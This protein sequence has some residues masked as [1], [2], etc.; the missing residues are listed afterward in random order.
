MRKKIVNLG[1]AASGSGTDVDS[2]MKAWIQGCLP[3]INPKLLI[4]T[5]SGAGCLSKADGYHL[6]AVTIDRAKSVSSDD[7]NLRILRRLKDKNIELFFLLGCIHRIIPVDGIDT[8]NIHPADPGRHGGDR[9]YGLAVHLHVLE[10]INDLIYRGRKKIT[11]RFYTFP[12]VHEVTDA[13][14]D[15]GNILLQQT[16]EIPKSIVRD[17]VEGKKDE[18]LVAEELQKHVLPYEWLMLPAA[19]KMAAQR[20]LDE[21]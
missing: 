11:D 3:E 4:S 14:Y 20:I 19:V 8:Y 5:K 15:A 7:F 16:V 13:K 1:F 18:L 2:V 9:M 17:Y 6:S 21:E 12:T 10:E